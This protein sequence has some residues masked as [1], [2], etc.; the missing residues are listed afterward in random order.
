CRMRLYF[1]L[2][3]KHRTGSGPR[4]EAAWRWQG[5]ALR[6]KATRRWRAPAIAV[7][8]SLPACLLIMCR[9]RSCRMRLYFELR[10]KHRTGSGPRSSW[11][12][13]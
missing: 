1:E 4:Y 13:S 6:H 3:S 10:S 8:P 5:Q 9:Q 7:R 11:H 2:R 12:D